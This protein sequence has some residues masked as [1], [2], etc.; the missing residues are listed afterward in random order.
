MGEGCA[1]RDPR[2]KVLPVRR[3][4]LLIRFE[5]SRSSHYLAE[6]IVRRLPR[7][8]WEERKEKGREG[9]GDR[10][11]PFLRPFEGEGLVSRC[12]KMTKSRGGLRGNSS[13]R[14]NCSSDI[15]TGDIGSKMWIPG[16]RSLIVQ[17]HQVHNCVHKALEG[18]GAF[19]PPASSLKVSPY[20]V[21]EVK[22]AFK[23][24]HGR[25]SSD[26]RSRP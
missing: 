24:R 26:G 25:T 23:R 15:L 8:S 21:K 2:R 14:G 22:S 9:S 16:T 18:A 11:S 20:V 1:T 3:T 12:L 5:A 7:P 4:F 13:F 6:R 10:S 17:I 19:W